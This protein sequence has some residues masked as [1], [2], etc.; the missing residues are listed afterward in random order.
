VVIISQPQAAINQ[1]PSKPK[2]SHVERLEQLPGDILLVVGR[3]NSLLYSMKGDWGW[4]GDVR[5][6]CASEI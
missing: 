4:K 3:N 1:V 5:N 6:Y 2:S